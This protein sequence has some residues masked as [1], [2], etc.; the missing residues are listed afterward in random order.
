[1]ELLHYVN[2]IS[3]YISNFRKHSGVVLGRTLRIFSE[4]VCYE[5]VLFCLGQEVVFFLMVLY[6]DLN[7]K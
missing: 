4:G 7:F 2:I 6:Y 3:R 5:K 1:M